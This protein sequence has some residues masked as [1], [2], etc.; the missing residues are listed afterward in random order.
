MFTLTQCLGLGDEGLFAPRRVSW[1]ISRR[2]PLGKAGSWKA[3]EEETTWC[4]PH[5]F[6]P[7]PAA[8]G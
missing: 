7:H 8:P 1:G 2:T 3:E 6:P 5:P 4:P